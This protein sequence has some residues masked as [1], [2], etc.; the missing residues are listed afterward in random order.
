M[1]TKLV[2]PEC[3]GTLGHAEP[4]ETPCKC[5]S[6]KRG[7]SRGPAPA[8]AQH[9]SDS[10]AG[11]PAAR[12]SSSSSRSSSVESETAGVEKIKGAKRCIVCG[13]DVTGHR[14]LKDSR[15]YIC[16]ACAKAEKAA[17]RE[18]K[19][20]CKEC[21]KLVKPEG[22]VAYEGKMICRKCYGDH[23]ETSRFR[24]KVST[25]HFEKHE[26]KTLMILVT[27]FGVLA[28]IVAYAYFFHR[29]H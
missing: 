5:F 25:K 6:T 3:G 9:S 22:L 29:S 24:K 13:K 7:G 23:Q 1:S 2:C 11:A 12:S 21:R 16:Y 19:V 14:R 10:A 4:G 26:K 27:V 18:G 20:A 28:A 15:G 8:V 17:E